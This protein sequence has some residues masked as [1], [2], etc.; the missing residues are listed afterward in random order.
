M[1]AIHLHR[2][3]MN[4]LLR[5]YR[6]PAQPPLPSVTC[7]HGR[8]SSRRLHLI[9]LAATT[10]AAESR[11]TPL[12]PTATIQGSDMNVLPFKFTISSAQATAI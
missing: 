4:G 8:A 9:H 10:A 7:E 12:K 2:G 6:T 1:V 11:R 5:P 3:I